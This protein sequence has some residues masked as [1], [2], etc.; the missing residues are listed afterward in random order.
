MYNK[1]HKC[2]T[3]TMSQSSGAQFKVVKV[4]Q[5]PSRPQMTTNL[6]RI[7]SSLFSDGK[8]ENLLQDLLALGDNESTADKKS[9][10][11]LIGRRYSS[12]HNGAVKD[13]E[14]GRMLFEILG[15]NEDKN[16]AAKN[17]ASQSEFFPWDSNAKGNSLHHPSHRIQR[18]DS[19]ASLRS[20]Q[21][22]RPTSIGS[23]SLSRHN[24]SALLPKV[25]STIGGFQEP[26]VVQESE[27]FPI[28]D[29]S[30]VSGSE[31]S[32]TVKDAY[33]F[34]DTLE[35]YHMKSLTEEQRETLKESGLRSKPK[36]RN[37]VLFFDDYDFLFNTPE[38][39]SFD[40]AKFDE[41]KV[42]DYRTFLIRE[43]V[44]SVLSAYKLSLLHAPAKSCIWSAMM[45]RTAFHLRR[46]GY[47]NVRIEDQVEG[48]QHK[49]ASLFLQGYHIS[50][51]NFTKLCRSVLKKEVKDLRDSEILAMVNKSA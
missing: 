33:W 16:G 9:R 47:N 39:V 40:E 29:S 12:E 32:I 4:E 27:T 8:A 50:R 11:F 34:L 5:Q 19:F 24:S 30:T 26:N 45:I 2:K 1:G 43:S 48:V 20:D 10:R 44:R 36:H 37:A 6:K 38:P 35:E 42:S 28:I 18:L 21:Q 46:S 49:E 31:P 23:I 15:I 22:G 3:H 17:S 13:L 7:S 41:S 51:S 14:D 25:S